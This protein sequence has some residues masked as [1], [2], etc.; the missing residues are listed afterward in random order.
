MVLDMESEF[1]KM[2]KDIL[3]RPKNFYKVF[4]LSPK[5]GRL[6]L[7]GA[8]GG[9]IVGPKLMYYFIEGPEKRAYKY[10]KTV[11]RDLFGALIKEFDE[12]VE[13]LPPKKLVE[14]G[15]ALS[16]TLG[17]GELRVIKNVALPIDVK[18]RLQKPG[19]CA[20]QPA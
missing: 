7:M 1:Y 17:W 20:Q 9:I 18:F 19:A 4:A 15:A 8:E 3:S 16:K 5:T 2:A 10:G 11:S 12:E 13:K 14:L 6:T